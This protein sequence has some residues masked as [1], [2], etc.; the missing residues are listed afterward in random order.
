M[1]FDNDVHDVAVETFTCELEPITSRQWLVRVARLPEFDFLTFKLNLYDEDLLWRNIADIPPIAIDLIELALA[2]YAVDRSIQPDEL[3]YCRVE[4]KLPVRCPELLRQPEIHEMLGEILYWYTGYEWN[5]E[6]G[7]R[8]QPGRGLEE[9]QLFDWRDESKPLDVALWSGGLDCLAGL[10][11]RAFENTD[12]QFILCGTGANTVVHHLQRRIV[13]VLPKQMA[14][15]VKLLQVR[16]E[17]EDLSGNLPEMTRMRS[18]GFTFMLIGAVCA[19]LAG[20]NVLQ[21]YENGI[22]AINL[23]F[24]E[25]EVGLNHAHSVHPLSLMFIAEWLTQ[26]FGVRFRLENPYLFQT[27]AQMCKIIVTK[28]GLDIA[29]QTETCDRKHRRPDAQQCGRCSSCILRRHAFAAL[30]I[31]DQTPYVYGL[32]DWLYEPVPFEVIDDGNHIPAVLYQV[33]NLNEHL[34]K[35]NPWNSLARQYETLAADIVDRTSVYYGLSEQEMRK[36]LLQ[37]LS[38]YVHEWFSL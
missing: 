38:R 26:I 5:F 15:R 24:R 22:G 31:H 32:S 35:S 7:K 1:K 20:S 11:N 18:R 3:S 2:V 19:H 10:Y 17:I 25:S 34:N 9:P 27:K 4:V 33:R 36:G 29:F 21:V 12:R 30:H 13:E 23:R 8:E 6:F 28:G 14:Q 37:L 16:Y